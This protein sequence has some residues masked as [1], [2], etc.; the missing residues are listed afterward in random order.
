MAEKFK[1][2]HDNLLQHRTLAGWHKTARDLA[3]TRE[4]S[5]HIAE[6]A[7]KV[8]AFQAKVDDNAWMLA[9]RFYVLRR[10]K[11]L[12]RCILMWSTWT[13]IVFMEEQG[14]ERFEEQ[15]RKL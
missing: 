13:R 14:E 2:K 5:A 15:Y 6:H 3:I 12:Q 9:N 4:R 11:L 8:K 1:K 7:E 10:S